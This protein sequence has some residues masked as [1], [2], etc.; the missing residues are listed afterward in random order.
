MVHGLTVTNLPCVTENYIDGP[1]MT[2]LSSQI[3]NPNSYVIKHSVMVPLGKLM[4]LQTRCYDYG[5]FQKPRDGAENDVISN[6][7]SVDGSSDSCS[8][9]SKSETDDIDVEILEDISSESHARDL[10]SQAS[11]KLVN[12]CNDAFHESDQPPVS[13]VFLQSRTQNRNIPSKLKGRS[14]AVKSQS[15]DGHILCKICGDKASGFHYGVFSCEGCKGFF[16]RTVRQKLV[17]KPCENPNGCLIMRISRNRCQYCRMQ[18]CILAGM[19]HEAVRLGRCPK[20]D[21]PKKMDF[22]KLP[23]NKH[24]KVDI[25]KQIRSEQMVLTI[26]DAFRTAIKDCLTATRPTSFKHLTITC[27]NDA[28]RFCSQYVTDMVR[29]ISVF[30]REIPQ[31]TQMDVSDQKTLIKH[32]ILESII[33]HSVSVSPSESEERIESLEDSTTNMEGP[34]IK[35]IYDVVSCVKKLRALKLTEVELAIF[36]AMLLFCAVWR[37]T[38]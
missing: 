20:K 21:K 32:C 7:T 27:E 2:D 10:N 15:V 4:K 35:L 36:A 33:I 22:F 19:S 29:F 30:A 31:F 13:E 11:R 17:Y 12:C 25:D 8:N 9:S 5:Q 6:V 24:G 38:T 18:R 37:E 1:K 14:G 26:H 28:R 34:L 23:Q 16:R 3:D